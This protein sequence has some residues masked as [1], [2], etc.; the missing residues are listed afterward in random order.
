VCDVLHNGF[1]AHAGCSASV[2]RASTSIH[3][4]AG[5][6]SGCVGRRVAGDRRASR[7][8]VRLAI[9]LP[10]VVGCLLVS[11]V[12][13]DKPAT[14]GYADH[15][16]LLV[17]RDAAGARRA[18][19]VPADWAIRRGHILAG[20]QEAMGPLPDRSKLP[21]LDVKVK[22]RLQGD[23]F[24]RFDITFASERTDRVPALLYLPA[25]CSKTRRAPAM[26]ALHPTS[27]LGRHRVT[28]KGGIPNRM[29]ADEL[30]RRG[31][32][33]IAP[34]YPPYGDYK[35]YDPNG[36]VSGTMKGIFDH[37]RCVD[38]LRSREEVDP[39][40]IGAIGHSLGGHNAMFVGVFDER[41]KVVVSS[42]GWTPF[43][44]YYGG[45][46]EGWTSD[47]YMPL[48]RTKYGLNPDRVPFDFYEVVAALAPRAFFSNSPL[49]DS[50]FGV[51][52]VRK[53]IP[54][55]R[56]VYKLLGALDALQVRYPDAPHDFPPDV[57]REA[58]AFID[59]VFDHRPACNAP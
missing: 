16:E 27:K 45:K 38:L 40:R 55:A 20:M 43:H 5:C 41:I 23:G 6:Q 8:A 47:R 37:M 31:Y 10:L 11:P 25:G 50:N 49:R 4:A 9:C 48:L 44:D 35:A 36:Y 1:V 12:S 32:V 18:V 24:E 28:A 15:S 33:V 19:K 39:N 3:G 7:I 42:C 29:Y 46:I 52:G 56:A 2:R 21:R 17:Y 22:E 51:A 34:D 59:G 26:L 53:A 54:K 57:R 30:A 58:Y 14:P 13:G